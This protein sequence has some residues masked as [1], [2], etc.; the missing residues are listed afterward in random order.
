MVKKNFVVKN[1][2][3]YLN[4]KIIKMNSTLTNETEPIPPSKKDIKPFTIKKMNMEIILQSPFLSQFTNK[5]DP[6]SL[7]S[8]NMDKLIDELIF[9][10]NTYSISNFHD[11]FSLFKKALNFERLLRKT[12]IDSLLK[13]CKSKFL[14]AVQEV[15]KKIMGDCNRLIELYQL[16]QRFITN[17]NIDYNKKYLNKTLFQIYCDLKVINSHNDI[18]SGLN[19]EQAILLSKVMNQNYKN[20]FFEYLHSKRY[21]I[22][23]KYICQKEGEKFELL[24]R[25]VSKIFINYYILSK[26]NKTK[27]PEV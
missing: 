10:Q 6:K 26:G 19:R 5:E 16:P 18:Y 12:K 22:D 24:F 27:N 17:V 13:K 1:N 8:F 3:F 15:I 23:C 9:Y 4:K 21:E 2:G 11:N 7:S 14:R 25:Y 20:L